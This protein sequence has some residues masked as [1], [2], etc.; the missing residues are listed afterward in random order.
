M[1]VPF[2]EVLSQRVSVGQ[3]DQLQ[4]RGDSHGALLLGSH[5]GDARHLFEKFEK[6]KVL[7]PRVYKQHGELISFR[8]GGAILFLLGQEALKI[9]RDLN[10]MESHLV[11]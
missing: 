4:A 7:R 1:T 9:I 11:K 3:G 8:S 2:Q 10:L 6:A 5:A